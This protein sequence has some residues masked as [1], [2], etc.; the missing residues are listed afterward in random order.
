M[1]DLT[2][3]ANEL[4]RLTGYSSK[5]P[6]LQLAELH[7]LGYFRARRGRVTGAVICERA[8]VEAVAAGTSAAPIGTARNRPKLRAVK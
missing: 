3:S 8:H 5:R 6:G 2:L 1:I 4:E 7:R